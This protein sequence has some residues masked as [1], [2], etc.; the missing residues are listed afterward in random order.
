MTKISKILAVFVAVASL[1][2]VGFA[3]AST[4][5]GPDW[6]QVTSADYFRGYSF[7]R[8]EGAEPVWGATRASDNGQVASSKVL[9]D[10]LSKVM[11]EVQQRMQQ[12]LQDLEGREPQ[13]RTRIEELATFQERDEQ[14][15][16]EHVTK[17][18]TLLDNLVKQ[19]SEL[20]SRVT[21]MV[22][23]ARKLERQTEARREDIFRLS[24]EV[25]ELK[26]DLF[27]LQVIREQLRDLDYQFKEHLDRARQRKALLN[28]EYNPPASS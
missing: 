3:I 5:G 9:P 24:Q 22:V 8:S 16:A 4:F 1:M 17:I 21:A 15:L 28:N 13:L 27:R 7:S 25:E 12:E 14:A 11:D 2:F 18:R 20:T 10:V 6:L 19:E 23:D 26:A